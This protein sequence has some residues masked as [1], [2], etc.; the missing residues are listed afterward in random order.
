MTVYGILPS[1]IPSST[2]S[3]LTNAIGVLPGKKDTVDEFTSLPSVGSETETGTVTRAVGRV[4]IRNPNVRSSDAPSFASVVVY[5]PPTEKPACTA[6]RQGENSDV[7]AV[8]GSVAV[9]VMNRP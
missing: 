5:G 9:A 4:S 7:P 8:A 3:T 6:C 1:S 2:P